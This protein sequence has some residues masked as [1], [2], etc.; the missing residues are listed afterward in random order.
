MAGG[1]LQTAIWPLMIESEKVSMSDGRTTQRPRRRLT[2][3]LEN[4]HGRG[5]LC[6]FP[7]NPSGIQCERADS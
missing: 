2:H 6:R 5:G 1:T 7:G 4:L 3:S